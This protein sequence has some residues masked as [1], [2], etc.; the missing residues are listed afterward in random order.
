[1]RLLKLLL[2]ALLVVVG[3]LYGFTEARALLSD[4]DVPPQISGTETLLEI[5]V[6]DGEEALLAGLTASD[7]QD[8]DL[9]DKIMIRGV[10]RLVTNDTAKVYYIVFD[11]DG[12]AAS[13]SRMI[14][15][16][17]YEKPHF[18]LSRA[19]VYTQDEDI[20]LLDRL[21]VQDVVD[22]D[23]TDSVRVSSLAPTSDPE[24]KTVAVQVTNSMGDTARLTLPIVTYSGAELRP[25]IMLKEYLVYLNQ[26]DAFDARSYVAIVSTTDGQGSTRDVQITDTVDTGTPGT[27]YVYY[28]YYHNYTV[29]L[30][31]LTVV[32]E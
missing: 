25:R 21:T 30:C 5:S 7:R 26:G 22:G 32:V 3:A 17:D 24:I 4:A 27:Y 1:M 19:L 8:G 10:S 23:I 6:A 15:Y 20:T 29:G 14:R 11:S 31:V 16:V 18:K 13:A 9:T 28:R 2:I 12:N